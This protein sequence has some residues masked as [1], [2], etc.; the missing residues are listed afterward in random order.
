MGEPIKLQT[1]NCKLQTANCKLPNGQADKPTSRQAVA[2][3]L[4]IPPEAGA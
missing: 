2:I 4:A 1:A 3:S